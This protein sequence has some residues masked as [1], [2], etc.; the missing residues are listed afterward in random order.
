MVCEHEIPLLVH[1]DA[2]DPDC[3]EVSVDGSVAGRPYRFVLDTG[4]R[5]THVVADEF[6]A[7]LADEGVRDSAGVFATRTDT[8]VTL[9]DVCVGAT[10]PMTLSTAVLLPASQPGARNLLGMDF[11][12]HYQCHFLFDRRL[13]LLAVSESAGAT[14]ALHTD[15]AF[16]P[17]VD[18]GWDRA[19]ASCVWDSGAGITVVDRGFR[20][21]NEGLFEPAGVSVGTDATGTQVRTPT[22]LMAPVRIGGEL[23]ASHRVAEVDLSVANRTLER[24]M[25]VLLGWTT[26]RQANWLFDFPARRWAVTTC[27]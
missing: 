4:A 22:Y 27:P 16:H 21:Q 11:L 3:A 9:P 7:G 10:P 13:L 17:Y 23:F 2:D 5:S 15:D 6:T 1:A 18:A 24:P 19:G 25:D 14:L 8:A 12:R 20:Q 26:L